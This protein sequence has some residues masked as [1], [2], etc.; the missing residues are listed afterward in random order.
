[1]PHKDKTYIKYLKSIPVWLCFIPAAILNGG[2]REYVL[3][4]YLD[5]ASAT[6]VSGILLSVLILLITWVLLP[7]LVTLNK[8]ESYMTGVIWM[9]LTVLFEFTSGIG[10]GVPMEELIAA[11]NPLSGN[12]WILVILTTMFSSVIISG[13]KTSYK[14]ETKDRIVELY[15]GE[16][17]ECQLMESILKDNGI[18]CFLK[19]NI[20][21]GYGPIVSPAE[22][23]L[24]MIN[25]SDMEKGLTILESI[26]LN[27]SEERHDKQ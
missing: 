6:V 18:D 22:Q 2:F 3:T 27:L 23:V 8:K 17:W 10:T 5:I 16:L 9:L 11:Y 7:R 1:M 20:R 24:I 15:R 19:N 12:L 26:N 21:S 25:E 14:S 4:K 13:K